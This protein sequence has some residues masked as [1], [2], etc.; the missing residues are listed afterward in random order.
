MSR[1]TETIQA[2]QVKM[3]VNKY[4]HPAQMIPQLLKQE[5]M[6]SLRD[7]YNEPENFRIRGY[8]E[9][10]DNFYFEKVF[11]CGIIKEQNV[12]SRVL[13]YQ[14]DYLPPDGCESEEEETLSTKMFLDDV[15]ELRNIVKAALLE[16]LNG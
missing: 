11:T 10:L 12:L 3:Q 15:R 8:L 1:R 4:V 13:R 6:Q 16:C 14:Q 9:Q 2:K 5:D 7:E